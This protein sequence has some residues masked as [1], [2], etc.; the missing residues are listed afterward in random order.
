MSS[1]TSRTA[2]FRFLTR[3]S[4]IPELGELVVMGGEDGFRPNPLVEV[5][6]HRPCDGHPVVGRGSPTDLVQ[7][8]QAR[9]RG[10]VDDGGRLVHLHH[11][12]GL[13]PGQGVGGPDPREDPV[14]DREAG[15]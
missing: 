6:R 2:T 14:A 5:L 12:G 3:G 11:E 13:T 7:E 1:P 4:K 15:G 8:D 10:A 9:F